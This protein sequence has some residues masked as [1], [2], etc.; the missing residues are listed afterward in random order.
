MAN[1]LLGIG[2]LA[3]ELSV[4]ESFPGGRIGALLEKTAVPISVMFSGVSLVAC[5][6]VF[7][8]D[9]INVF[10]FGGLLATAVLILT[11]IPIYWGLR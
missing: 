5:P 11:P 10:S 9:I 7:L 1:T 6:I 2:Y 4:W 3:D 8:T